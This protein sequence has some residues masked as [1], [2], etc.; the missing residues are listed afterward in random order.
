MKNLSNFCYFFAKIVI[1]RADFDQI[2]SEFHEISRNIL[3]TSNIQLF[4]NIGCLTTSKFFQTSIKHQTSTS[5]PNLIAR[6]VHTL[7]R[8]GEEPSRRAAKPFM[9]RPT[10]GRA[11]LADCRDLRCAPK[12]A[13]R[14][15]IPNAWRTNSSLFDELLTNFWQ[16]FW[17]KFWKSCKIW[18]LSSR[19]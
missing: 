1:F 2:L 7:A 6:P 16:I 19:E 18:K 10:K 12:H 9:V 3:D 8:K 14:H 5:T 11:R 15:P 17:Q 13:V 4:S